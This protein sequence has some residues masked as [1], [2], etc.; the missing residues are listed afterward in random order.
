MHK[1]KKLAEKLSILIFFAF[2]LSVFASCSKSTQKKSFISSLDS[3]DA[4]I[5]QGFYSDALKELKSLEKNAFNSWTV[6]GLTKRYLKIS[7][8]ES[9]KS[10]LI[11]FYKK[12]K[13]PE[14]CAIL[15][16][17]FLKDNDFENAI[18]YG[19]NLIGTK[20]GS[21]YSE[22]VFSSALKNQQNEDSYFSSDFY[23]VYFDAFTGSQNQAWLQNCAVLNLLEGKYSEA[24]K[25]SPENAKN[26]YFWSLVNFDGEHFAESAFYGEN[27]VQNL[28]IKNEN[29]KDFG[30]IVCL[31]SDSYNYL[32]DF[33]GAQKIRQKYIETENI[34]KF[35]AENIFTPIIYTN[36]AI[37]EFQ[38]KNYQEAK[39][40]IIDVLNYFP[41]NF[42]ALCVYADFSNKTNE[43]KSESFEQKTLHDYGMASLEME[44]YEN[45]V[46]IP[47][48]DVISRVSSSLK[49]KKSVELEILYFDL[50]YAK[51]KKYSLQEKTFE[52]YKILEN[53]QISKNIYPDFLVNYAVDF[54]LS[55][56]KTEEAQNLLYN[57]IFSKYNFLP[58]E[59]FWK[60]VISNM[61][62][63]N[64]KQVEYLAYFALLQELEQESLVLSEYCAYDYF[65]S[66]DDFALSS[67]IS[68]FSAINLGDIYYS[69]GKVSSA[70]KL[71]SK[72]TGIVQDEGLKSLIFYRIAKIYYDQKDFINAKI[73]AQYSV[74]LNIRNVEA[75]FL[76]T[77]LEKEKPEMF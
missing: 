50:V 13:N 44:K 24:L 34:K 14:V 77:R 76:L 16:N 29:L 28:K 19:K 46:K 3:V 67:K 60:N 68:K 64:L 58:E 42:S 22:A 36:S 10:L 61:E 48:S 65:N 54:F 40:L 43:Q 17:L 57:F 71:Y 66:F 45:R 32:A 9:A 72:L 49:Q 52:L 55:N 11:S 5:K 26:P 35:D 6:L 25:L 33:S 21:F 73:N 12:N 15:T 4:L 7:E 51:S 62:K 56:K 53:N 23:S 2:F 47:F 31:I 8:N 1:V 59:D 18:S 74:S 37:F 63:I 75:K 30:K 20:Y 38:N 41:D 27:F 39:D 70:I 69:S